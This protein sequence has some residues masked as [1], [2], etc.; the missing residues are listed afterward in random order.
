MPASFDGSV[1]GQTVLIG[2]SATREATRA[3][4]DALALKNNDA[5]GYLL[6]VSRRATP[7]ADVMASAKEMAA[8]LSR[9]GHEVTVVHRAAE[10]ADIADVLMREAFERGA[11]MIV[12]GAFGHSVVYDF[13]IGAV[14]HDLMQQATVPVLFSK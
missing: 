5:T 4:F 8:T 1:I 12:S 3:A 14:T 10:G 7:D 13:V 2:W 9:H 6:T 11:D